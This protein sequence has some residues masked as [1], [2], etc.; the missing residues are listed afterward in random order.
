[1]KSSILSL[2]PLASLAIAESSC[3]R[4]TVTHTKYEKVYKTVEPVVDAK[5]EPTCS[6]QTVTATS[7]EKVYVTVTPGASSSGIPYPTISSHSKGPEYSLGYTPVPLSEV[8]KRTSTI[9]SYPTIS[10]Y[11]KEP[12]YSLNYTPIPLSEVEKRTSTIPSHPTISSYTKEPEYSLNYTPIPLSEVAKPTSTVPSHPT[13]ASQS[14]QPEYSLNYT[15]VPQSEVAKP[16]SAPEPAA[17]ADVSAAAGSNKGEATF[18]G[19]NVAGGMC[20]FT[21]YTIPAG[22]FGTALSSSNWDG[23]AN[24]GTCVQVTGPSGT[25]IKAMVVD[26]CPG[27]GPNHLDLFPDAF[28]QLADPTKGVIPVSWDIVSCGITTPI[29]LKNKEGTSKFWFSMQVMNSNVKVSKLEV[30]TD[31]GSSW[32]STT[33]KEYNY[34][35]NPSGF[36]AD[37]VDVK[38]TSVN[39]DSIVVKDV[40]IAASSTKTSKGNFA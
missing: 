29:V 40:S 30:S 38:V 13:I 33:R 3:T 16:S 39:G 34:F 7:Y 1:M 24:C 25:K 9:A 17:R 23:A 22:I 19:G 32:K 27:C 36:G 20:S 21:G 12:E 2:L 4:K 6:R 10:S 28:K 31:G 5:A 18:Y 35:E 11:T 37:S 15:P 26:Q 8:E 14:K